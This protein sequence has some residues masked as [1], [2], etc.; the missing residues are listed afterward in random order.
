MLRLETAA[1]FAHYPAFADAGL[2]RQQHDLAF[3]VLRQ[4]PALEQ[5]A[6]LA[7]AADKTGRPSAPHRLESTLGRTLADHPQGSNRCIQALDLD[8]TKLFIFE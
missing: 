4:L 8:R 6:E 1:Q 5:Q 2:A 3:A 7:L